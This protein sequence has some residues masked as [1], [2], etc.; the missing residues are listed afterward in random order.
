MATEY[1]YPFEVP[2]DEHQDHADRLQQDLARIGG[3]VTE[4]GPGPKGS[5]HVVLAAH[6]ERAILARFVRGYYRRGG[7]DEDEI[8]IEVGR[9]REA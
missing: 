3:T 4:S 2:A 9:I 1:V 6:P 8:E 5:D 7:F